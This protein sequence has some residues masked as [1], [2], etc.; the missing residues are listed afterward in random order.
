M[1]ILPLQYAKAATYT[2]PL[3]GKTIHN[4]DMWTPVHSQE[5]QFVQPMTHG[6]LVFFENSTVFNWQPTDPFR[7][8]IQILYQIA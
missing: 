7:L 5:S 4:P 6:N 3:T 2:D 1:I 8:Q